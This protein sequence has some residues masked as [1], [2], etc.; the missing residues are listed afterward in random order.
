VVTPPSSHEPPTFQRAL[1]IA[2]P[3]AGRGRGA[4]A[5]AELQ[6]G[7]LALGLAAELVQTRGA[8][9]AR[10][11]AADL[12]PGFDLVVAVGGDGTLGEVLSGLVRPS[13]PVAVLP[14]GTAN[15]LARDLGLPTDVPGL[16]RMVARGRVLSIDVAQVGE[17]CSF[18]ATSVGFDAMVVQALCEA[19]RGPIS[20][21]SYVAPALRVLAGYRP[22]RLSVWLD[23]ERL[24][25]TYGMALF[26]NCIHY[27]GVLRLCPG[28]VL[29]DGAFE[30]FLFASAGA[31]DLA[32]G[33]AR[34]LLG[35]LPGGH[36][37]LRRARHM[38]VE[39]EAPCPYQVDGD[40]GGMTPFE[41]TV[42]PVPHHLLVPW[43][44]P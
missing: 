12:A 5:A 8:G 42:Q 24:E 18:L 19:R 16:L 14:L 29:D 43:I 26:S 34:G 10:R 41:L 30:V 20:K 36:C 37:T 2:N 39:S 9:E 44:D 32:A 17:R 15:V 27:G 31:L 13:L 23:G 28:R 38:R 11:A 3:I 22:P 35:R 33:F 1:V 7:L 6:R 21:L 40:A 25:G 4:R